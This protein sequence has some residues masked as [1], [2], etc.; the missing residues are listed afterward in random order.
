[1]CHLDTAAR[2]PRL[3]T[4]HA[5]GQAAF[6]A[7]IEP[8]RCSE[9]AWRA[10]I[11]R[12][13]TL[14]A[15]C[16]DGNV[17]AVA[18]VPSAAHGVS[19]A[20]RNLPLA[21]GDAVLVADAPHPSALLAWQQR[22][23]Q[24]DARVVAATPV[25]GESRTDAVLRLL[26][27]DPAIRIAMLSQ[28]DWH[29][30]GV[31]DLDAIARCAQARNVVLVLDLSQSLGALPV[32]LARWAPAFAVSVA[33]KWL[34]GPD[35]LA[36]LWVAPQWREAGSSIEQHWLARDGGTAWRFDPARP[37]A[38]GVGARRYDAG[39]A[40]DPMRLAMAAAALAQMARWRIERIAPALQAR[41]AALRAALRTH[42]LAGWMPGDDTPSHIIGLRPPAPALQPVATALAAAGVI[43]TVR[44][45]IVR[46]APHLNVATTDMDG[47][48]RLLA[49]V[50]AA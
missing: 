26:E 11:E 42:G 39:G 17:D 8:W 9:V 5:A 30:G 44:H 29:D 14:A 1:M 27:H 48:A 4:V 18:L 23:A 40:A 35:G 37:T 3:R 38:Y 46:I 50:A 10:A 7:G 20:A 21:R 22:C 36:F 45:G 24:C 2:A 15:A 33:S 34:L 49:G 31:V 12:V 25:A 43:A 13:R 47:V 41:V 32:D 19:I 16:L 6:D 28:V